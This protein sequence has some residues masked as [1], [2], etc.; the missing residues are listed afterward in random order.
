MVKVKLYVSTGIVGSE[1]EDIIE[2]PDEE[3]EGLIEEKRNEVF[4]E[5]LDVFMTNYCDFGWF[6]L[7]DEEE[8]N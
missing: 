2:I 1:R 5:A 4:Q 6:V 8:E 7:D 3:L